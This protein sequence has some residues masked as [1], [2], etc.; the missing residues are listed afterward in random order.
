M[1]MPALSA[2][3]SAYHLRDH[4]FALFRDLIQGET[5]IQ[6]PESKRPLL[7][8]RLARRLR[9][10]KIDSFEAYFRRVTREGDQA[11]HL[12]M[13]DQL[14]T[15]ETRFFRE[16]AQFE[17]LEQRLLPRWA[18]GAARSAIRV[19]SAACST[20]EEPYSIAMMLLGRFP[21]WEIEIHA[22][23]LSN[24]ALDQA[25]AAMWPIERRREIPERHLK[26][27]ML[28]GVGEYRAR[29]K[30]R[31]ELRERISFSRINLHDAGYPLEGEFDLIFCRNVLIY[32]SADGRRK[33]VDQLIDRL[34][35]GG[36]LL[37]GHAETAN[38][39]TER[40]RN[41]GSAIYSRQDGSRPARK[42]QFPRSFFFM[43][44]SR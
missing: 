12:R 2:L 28:R 37:L 1:N 36:F 20:G 15:N 33:V 44:K 11:E 35:P 26:A 10:L 32:F 34:A 17:A 18:G 16:P 5:G 6:L 7:V 9:E 8:S 27:F 41:E 4:E 14:T 42:G 43:E 40:L 25:R 13:I 39:L 21:G 31:P 38:G 3:P 22:S 19:W 23:D 30:A 29:M 24:R